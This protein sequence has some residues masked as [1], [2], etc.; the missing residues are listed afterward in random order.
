M[1]TILLALFF[2]LL[3]S[4]SGAE[5]PKLFRERSFTATDLAAAVNH[6]IEL[7]EEA[8][9]KE[10]SELAP[11]HD[12]GAK[13]FTLPERVSWV[14]RI[15]FQPKGDK[16]LREPRYGA[17]LLPYLSMPQSKWPLY[18][19]AASGD[20]FFVLSEGYSR[21]GRAEDPKKYLAYCRAK[22]TFRKIAVPV[23]TREQALKE[24]A[25]LHESGA[26]KAIKWQDSGKGSTYTI[27][28]AWKWR[29]IQAQADAIK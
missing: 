14:C 28:E 26:W 21:T 12:S 29:F 6:Y 24:V 20:S 23:P 25:L 10:L 16:P 22:G 13:G 11:D 1:K 4:I 7:G 19:L 18:P 17:V 2:G 15:L 9:V 27:S 3:S 8:A 5:V